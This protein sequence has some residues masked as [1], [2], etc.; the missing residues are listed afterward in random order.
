[1]SFELINPTL[2]YQESF[3]RFVDELVEAKDPFFGQYTKY[4]SF[5]KKQ[6]KENFYSY[7]VKPL[8]DAQ[9][10]IGLKEGHVPDSTLWLVDT[11]TKDILGRFSIRHRLTPALSEFGGHIGYVIRP[12]ARKHGYAKI[13]LDLSLDYCRE[14]LSLPEILVTCDARNEA[15]Y[16]TII[17]RMN[18][19]GGRIETPLALKDCDI[20]KSNP[21]HT[22]NKNNIELRFWLKT[23]KK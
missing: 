22:I 12:S 18:E 15:S 3:L 19:W 16:R 5:D 9:A 10:G 7:K 23:N 6:L 8:L 1:M 21:Y 2:E 17:G 13:G 14:K 11:N 20:F 4:A